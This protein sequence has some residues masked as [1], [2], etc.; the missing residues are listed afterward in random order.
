MALWKTEREIKYPIY[1]TRTWL[2]KIILKTG[3]GVARCV[4]CGSLAAIRPVEENLRESCRCSR[5]SATNRQRQLAYV[6]CGA[7]SSMTGRRVASLPE[8]ARLD[9]L[10]VY[11][12]EARGAVHGRL[13]AMK[14]YVCSEYFGDRYEPGALVNGVRHEDLQAL[15]LEDGTIDLVLSSDVFE[16]I[17]EPY[18]AHAEVYRVLKPGGRHVFT[19]PFYQ[20]EFLDEA[21]T[22][23]DDEGNMV[24]LMEPQYHGDPIRE[25][26]ALVH[27]IFSLEMLV[28]LRR[29]GFRPNLYHLYRPAL[30]IVGPNAIVFEAIKD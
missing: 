6:L 23:T 19:V 9:H 21:R 11:N 27:T 13:R 30:G 4:V 5:C 12:T 14:G 20:T 7:A 16:H 28:E 1:P 2:E 25:E 29:I 8:L 18:E 15:S 17:P 22:G 24:H 10:A 3:V 26:G